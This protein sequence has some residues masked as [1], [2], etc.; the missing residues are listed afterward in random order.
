ML[1]QCSQ[2]LK[3]VINTQERWVETD[4]E[5][6]DQVRISAFGH[7]FEEVGGSGFGHGTQVVDQIG[8]AH[9]DTGI[10]DGKGFG[11]GVVFELDLEVLLFTFVF[12]IFVLN[13]LFFTSY[14]DLFGFWSF[15]VLVGLLFSF[16]VFRFDFDIVSLFSQ[17]ISMNVNIRVKLL[18]LVY[19]IHWF[20]ENSAYPRN[21]SSITVI[22]F[23]NY[24]SCIE[25]SVVTTGRTK[26]HNS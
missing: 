20:L 7:R 22:K 9:T 26:N 11:I 5:L 16:V 8:F 6:T 2:H 17:W 4:T 23:W 25:T 10:D 1:K 15:W 12:L 19:K 18:L 21:F 3:I 24:L 13:S 14:F